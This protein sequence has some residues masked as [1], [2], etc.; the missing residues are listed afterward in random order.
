MSNKTKYTLFTRIRAGK[1]D[2]SPEAQSLLMDS[3]W[4]FIQFPSPRTA[5]GRDDK[6]MLKSQFVRTQ[7]SAK[8]L[9]KV[10]FSFFLYR[11]CFIFLLSGI[12]STLKKKKKKVT[13]IRQKNYTAVKKI[14]PYKFIFHLCSSMSNGKKCKFFNLTLV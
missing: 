9:E 8:N 5:L 11:N 4:Q 2:I 14:L 13:K 6:A 1:E 12:D 10:S 3:P 7:F